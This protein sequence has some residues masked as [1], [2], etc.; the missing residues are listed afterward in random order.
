RPGPPAVVTYRDALAFLYSQANYEHVVRPYTEVKLERM[1]RLLELDGNPHQR[2]PS[3]L[4][5]GTKGKG[6]IAAM[7]ASIGRAAGLRTG[8]YSSPHL[9]TH[10]ERYRIDG[11]PVPGDV[12][13][14]HMAALQEGAL[15]AYDK[16]EYGKP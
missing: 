14:R 3:I 7:L 10:R 8:F 6:S 16:P 12:F 2:F 13:A 1:E 15:A 9:A 11:Q 5:A 4:I